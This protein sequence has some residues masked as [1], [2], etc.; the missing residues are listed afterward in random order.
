MPAGREGI[1]KDLTFF[2]FSE[3]LGLQSDTLEFSK[4]EWTN[5]FNS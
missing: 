1:T 3:Y 5:M 2:V 4:Y